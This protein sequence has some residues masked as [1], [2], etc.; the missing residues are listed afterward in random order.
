MIN[1][2]D[3][4]IVFS[5]YVKFIKNDDNTIIINGLSGVWGL[6]D[7]PIL[8]KVNYC[9]D[10]K[11]APLS[12]INS[13]KD[14]SSKEQLTEVFESLIDEGMLKNLNNKDF[15]ISIKNVEFKLTNKCN[16]NCIHCAASSKISNPDI[17][18]THQILSILDKIFKLNIDELLL[19]GGEPLIRKDIKEI[20]RYIKKNFNGTV[21]LITNGT[22][23]DKEMAN[24]LKESVQSV[25]ISMDG[26]D[27]SSTE[28]VRGKGVYTKILQAVNNLKEAGFHKD[29]IL[30]SMTCTDQNFNHRDDFDKLCENLN[31]TGFVRQFSALGRGLDNYKDLGLKDYLLLTQ[32][33]NTDLET[34]RE[35]IECK[36]FCKAGLV[37]LMIDDLG[38]L[39]P[40][41][42]L[43]DKKYRLG[44]I[45]TE[46]FNDIFNSEKYAHFIKSQLKTSVVD[47]LSKCKN[48][49]VRYFCMDRCLGM[50]NSYFDNDHICEERCKQLKPYL[51][52][53]LWN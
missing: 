13:L 36:I 27:E 41:L 34:I 51:T 6:I 10:N 35:N 38:D 1:L 24:I 8:D 39:Y 12:Y 37:K 29:T 40:C 47:N 19:T 52:K 33:S 32:N 22:L 25:S 28:F 45:L 31:V 16:L 53:V 14:D 44:N 7:A 17:L 15:E 21:N 11:L 42:I 2:S 46:N 43:D 23:L 4:N 49:N 18:N 26:Y 50:T 5:E 3:T 30:L 9:I 48:C 20:L